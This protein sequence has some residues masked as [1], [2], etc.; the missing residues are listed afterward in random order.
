MIEKTIS[1]YSL[2]DPENNNG[3]LIVEVSTKHIACVLRNNARVEAFELYDLDIK[4]EKDFEEAFYEIRTQ[5]EL[6]DKGLKNVKLFYNLSESVIIPANKFDIKHRGELLDMVYGAQLHSIACH[7]QFEGDLINIFR[8]SQFWKDVLNRNFISISEKHLYTELAERTAA[9][10]TF[11]PHLLHLSFYKE[12]MIL[13]AMS[14]SQLQLVQKFTYKGPADPLYHLLNVCRHLNLAT[15]LTDL[16]LCGMI[17][18]ASETYTHIAKYFPGLVLDEMREDILNTA[19]IQ[20]YPAH[21]FTPYFSLG[22]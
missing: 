4:N 9:I 19:D 8:V 21:Y 1:S 5:S 10:E 18:L 7:E 11:S 22:V 17:E 2:L 12:E 15:E 6:L 20:S 16:R 13:I 3:E 14:K